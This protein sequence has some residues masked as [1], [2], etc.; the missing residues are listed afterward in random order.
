MREFY[1]EA[2]SHFFYIKE[3][4]RNHVSHSRTDYDDTEATRV[5]ARVRDFMTALAGRP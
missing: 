2:A 1:S 3:A 5:V 4:W